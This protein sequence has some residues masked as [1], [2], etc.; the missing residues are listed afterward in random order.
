MEKLHQ[1]LEKNTTASALAL[2]DLLGNI[3]LELVEGIACVGK[4]SASKRPKP[5]YVAHKKVKTLALLDEQYKGSNWWC[6]EVVGIWSPPSL[7]LRRASAIA[8]LW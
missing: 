3:R 5:F 7:K 6:L 8:H 4:D 1:T 2:R